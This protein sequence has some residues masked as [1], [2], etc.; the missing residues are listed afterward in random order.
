MQKPHFTDSQSAESVGAKWLLANTYSENLRD[1]MR[2]LAPKD[3]WH[4]S[5]GARLQALQEHEVRLAAVEQLIEHTYIML[6][7]CEAA[8]RTLYR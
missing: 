4:P 5:H 8:Y 1:A 7:H 3:E 2:D 6:G